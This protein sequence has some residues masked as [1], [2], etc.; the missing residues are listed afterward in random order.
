MV[1]QSIADGILA[2]TLLS[3]YELAVHAPEKLWQPWL[4]GQLDRVETAIAAIEKVAPTLGARVD[5][6]TISFACAFGYLD[7]R[8]ADFGWRSRHPHSAAWFASFKTRPS[9]QATQHPAG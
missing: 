8:F 4:D 1:D 3:R 2:A 7:L 9:M 6:G 5:L